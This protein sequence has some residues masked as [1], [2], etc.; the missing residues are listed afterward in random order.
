MTAM[1]AIVTVLVVAGGLYYRFHE[2]P[3]VQAAALLKRAVAVE[4]ARPQAPGGCVSALGIR[5]SRGW[6]E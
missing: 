1:A 3:S 6:R 2:T 4:A 5:K